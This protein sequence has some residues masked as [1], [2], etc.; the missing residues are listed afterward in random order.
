MN[1]QM[2][3]WMAGTRNEMLNCLLP[4]GGKNNCFSSCLVPQTLTRPQGAGTRQRVQCA[5]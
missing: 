1:G 2:D 4:E 3:C 5:H